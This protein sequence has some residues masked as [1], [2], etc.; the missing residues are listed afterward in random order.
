MVIWQNLG[1]FSS[2]ELFLP[3]MHFE[4]DRP[5]GLTGRVTLNVYLGKSLN[6]FTSA[7]AQMILVERG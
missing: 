4:I 1:Q 7:V 6:S 2:L 5:I 3:S